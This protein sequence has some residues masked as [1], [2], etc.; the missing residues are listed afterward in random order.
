MKNLLITTFLMVQ[1]TFSFSSDCAYSFLSKGN[2][3]YEENN[4]REAINQYNIALQLDSTLY[5]AR[6]SRGMAYFAN[7]EYT[8]A[9]IDFNTCVSFNPTDKT[10]WLQLALSNAA[11][12]NYFEAL[13][14]FEKCSELDPFDAAVY[15]YIEDCKIMLH[16]F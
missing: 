11:L 13:E 12:F 16:G 9:S 2:Q 4:F 8:A 5:A 7:E 1:T 15:R 10:A 3:A 6:F 14:D